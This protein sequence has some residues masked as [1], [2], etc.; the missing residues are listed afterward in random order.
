M[1]Y[2]PYS[3]DPSGEY[4]LIVTLHGYSANDRDAASSLAAQ[5]PDVFIAIAPYGRGDIGYRSIGEQDVLDVLAMAQQTYPVDPDRVYLTGS[6]MGGLG[7]W[8]IGIF[9]AD[10]FAAV[11]PFCGWTSI[12][13]LVNLRNVPVLI[14]HGDYD[15]SVPVE[16]SRAAAAALRDLGYNYVFEEL[17]GVG[18]D[19]WSGLVDIKGGQYLFDFFRQHKRNLWPAEIFFTTDYLRYGKHYWV[20]IEELALE[21]EE[22]SGHVWSM[23]WFRWLPAGSQP[24]HST[25]AIR[26]CPNIRE[27]PLPLTIRFWLLKRVAKESCSRAGAS[28]WR[29]PMTFLRERCVAWAADWRISSWIRW[30]SSTERQF[31]SAQVS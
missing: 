1:V 28:G 14:V 23:G 3:Y 12:W 18:H 19:A 11:A 31:P 26:P 15:T 4:S 29:P 24:F 6:S 8:R 7:A 17:P 21:W 25:C 27:W 20:Q 2:L 30:C 5:A 16:F 10:R 22:P 13:H 9:Y